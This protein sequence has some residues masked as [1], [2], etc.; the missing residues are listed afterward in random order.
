MTN[1]NKIKVACFGEVLWDLF[2]GKEKSAGGAPFNVA[3]NLFKMGID[4]RMIS[5]VGDD[6]PGR[7]I[8]KKIDSWNMPVK[9]IQLNKNYSTSTVVA[10]FD[11]HKEAHYDIVTNVA[12]DF[13]EATPQDIELIRNE[14]ALVFG[15][16]ATRSPQ[17]KNTL[18]TLLENSTFNVFDINLRKPH[19]DLS[20]IKDLLHKSH[21]AKFNK[22]ELLLLREFLGKKYDSEEDIVSYLQDTFKLPEVIVSKGS[23]GALYASDGNFYLYPAVD[24]V[25]ADTVGSGD[26][27]LAGFL[28][29]RLEKAASI[30]DIMK[31][32]VSLGAYITSKEG[33]CPEYEISDFKLFTKTQNSHSREEELND[34]IVNH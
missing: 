12:W 2:P 24:I 31:Q 14:D 10:T 9:S 28:S 19:Y 27:F 23:K 30:D 8:I 26:A 33:A 13:I 1:S 11:E 20:V 7:E 29:K 5:S 34:A 3:Y 4:S 15:S 17:S 22:A 32:A 18:F 16:L 6:D 21:L 25:V